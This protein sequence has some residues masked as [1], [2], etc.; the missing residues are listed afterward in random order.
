MEGTKWVGNLLLTSSIFCGPL[1]A[2][3]CV[4]NTVAIAY[5]VC[6]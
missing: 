6:V 1:F 3:F 2:I 5:G 4:N